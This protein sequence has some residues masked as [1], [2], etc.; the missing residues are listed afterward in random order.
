MAKFNDKISNIIN[1]QL[2]E[3]VVDQHPKFASFL[4][5][6][7]QLLESAELSVTSV[8]TTDGI[9]I[10]SETGK[11]DNIVLNS[12]SIGSTR[13][14]LDENDKI[15]LEDSDRGKFTRGETVTGQTS[16]ATAT[17]LVEDLDNNRLIISA[18]NKF[19]INETI[20]GQTSNASAKINN[21]RPSPVQNIIDLVNF[22]DPDN[23]VSSYLNQFRNEFLNTLPENLDSEID[24]RK[25]IKNIKSLYQS[26]GTNRGN[27]IFFRLLFNETAETI[28]PR[29]Q[30]LKASDGNWD[31]LKVM[32][33]I[34]DVG[35]TSKLIGRTITDTTTNATAIVENV[36]KFQVAEYEVSEFILNNESVNGTFSVGE[37]IR[38]TET[39]DDENYIKATITGIPGNKTVVNDG[40]LYSTSDSITLTGG[41]QSALL[42]IDNIGSGSIDEVIIDDPGSGFEVKD[43]LVFVNTGTSGI[44]AAGFVSVVGGGFTQETSTSTT[45]DHIVMED[46][47]TRGDQYTGNKIVQERETGPNLGDVEGDITDIYITNG[48]TGYLSLPT[49]TVSST[50]GTGSNVKAFGQNVGRVIGVK[51]LELGIQHE[52]SPSPPTLSFFNNI[53]AVDITGTV[54]SDTTVTGGTSGA[55]GTISSYNSD[56]GLIKVKSVTGTF[57]LNETVTASNGATFVIKKLDVA[58]VTLAVTSVFDTDGRFINEDGF[59]SENTMKIQDSLYYQ[60]FSYVIKVGRSINEWRDSFQKTMHT[61]GFYFTGQVDIETRLNARTATPIVGQVSGVSDEG[62][63]NIINTLFTTIFGRRLGTVDD[64]T[65]LRANARVAGHA[66][67]DTDTLTPFDKTTRDVTL[68]REPVEIDYLSR[69]RRTIDNVEVKTG[70]AY[71]GPRYGSLN[72]FANTVFGSSNPNSKITFEI[73]NDLKVF[74]TKTSLD[75]RNPIFLMTSNSDGQKIK[76]NFAFPSMTFFSANS[77][78]NVVIKFDDTDQTFDDTTP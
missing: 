63:F 14:L 43:P 36:R 30:L 39:D 51:T 67:F 2:P 3:F 74:G 6:Y 10:E 44:N 35:D 46:E 61:S 17:V 27:E 19:K 75:G 73:L 16:G 62:L 69:V 41:G 55:T 71:A 22:R 78:D 53:L 38:G 72:R 23:V 13:T 34:A 26:K 8:A 31:S 42:S 59:V 77:F 37:Q 45:N 57:E 15:L 1:A 7:F 49:V 54:L 5:L 70:Y 76:M 33:A 68:T 25:L 60:D 56:L 64:G 11:T 24:K 18:Q 29:D 9:T 58:N 47:T 20:L 65:T 50:S 32:R 66:D 40:A 4:K 52:L 12:S 28:Y 21:Y 48:G